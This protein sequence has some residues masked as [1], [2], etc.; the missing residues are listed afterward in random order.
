[1]AGHEQ[2]LGTDTSRRLHLPRPSHHRIRAA[3]QHPSRA[4]TQMT[5]WMYPEAQPAQAATRPVLSTPNSLICIAQLAN[6]RH[7]L[8]DQNGYA[9]AI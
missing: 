6:L 9:R 3:E 2:Q 5:G 4:K 8:A 7:Q 1:M